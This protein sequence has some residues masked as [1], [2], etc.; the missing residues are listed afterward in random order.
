[1]T[2]SIRTAVIGYGLG[3]ETFHA[4]L[5]A[6]TPGLEL[7]AIVTRDEG[8]RARARAAYPDVR[9]VSDVEAI[10]NPEANM[11]LVVITTPNAT[12]ARIARATIDAGIACVVDKPFAA[13]ANEARAID[14]LAREKGV[15]VVP[16]QNRRWDADFLTLRQ[17]I[18]DGALGSVFR[19]ESRFE[20]LRASPKPRW[21]SADALRSAEGI[22]YDLGP[23]VVDQALVLF[24]RVRDVYA[25]ADR[26]HPGVNA[27]DD[28]MIALTHA[29]GVRSHLFMSAVAAQ[30]GPRLSAY[31]TSGAFIKYG[32]DAQ[33]ESL[34]RGLRPG[35]PGWGDE[36][37]D[38]WGTLVS[39]GER[40]TVPSRPGAYETFYRGVVATLTRG[41][42]PPVPFEDMVTGLT[43]L[44]SAHRSAAE[45]RVV[46]LL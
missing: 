29:S 34:K 9:L 16:F 4:P 5:I 46:S 13:T 31:G 23:H 28:A 37:A 19:F 38:A 36:P 14:R 41:A 45:R 11:G 35:Q 2:A 24:G 42:P 18:D 10:L 26:R 39:N 21:T 12:H 32:L 7:S 20:R 15:V 22:I 6:A 27:E 17:L 30:S 33:E 40:R 3:G 44:E 8:R 43:V 25:E 1:V